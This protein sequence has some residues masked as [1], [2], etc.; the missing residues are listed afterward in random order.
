MMKRFF[1]FFHTVPSRCASGEITC[2]T[3]QGEF[4]SRHELAVAVAETGPNPVGC[5]PSEVNIT[6]WVEFDSEEDYRS[7]C[8][9]PASEVQDGN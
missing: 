1:V 2:M 3:D 5:K 6:G 7:Y 4:P 9:V 8:R